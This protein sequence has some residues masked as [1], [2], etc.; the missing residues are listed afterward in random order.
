MFKTNYQWQAILYKVPQ[1]AVG[2]VVGVIYVQKVQLVLLL[3]S[4]C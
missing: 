3:K 1:S 2:S 4:Y